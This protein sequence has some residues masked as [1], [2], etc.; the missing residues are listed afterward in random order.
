M[1][2]WSILPKAS[3]TLALSQRVTG[4]IMNVG[5]GVV[6]VADGLG[7]SVGLSVPVLV[8]A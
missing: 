7:L 2:T 4:S 3:L 6:G 8:G 5:A 1:E